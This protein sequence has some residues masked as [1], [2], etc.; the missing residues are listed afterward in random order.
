MYDSLMSGSSTWSFNTLPA[1]IVKNREFIMFYGTF[2]SSFKKHVDFSVFK[3]IE[4]SGINYEYNEK[5]L[6]Q[7]QGLKG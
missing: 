3:C 4:I 2:G 6:E 7:V 1:L 5:N